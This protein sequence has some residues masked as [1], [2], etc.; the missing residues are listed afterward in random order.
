M[1]KNVYY[2]K[3]N[4]ILFKNL[5]EKNHICQYKKTWFTNVSYQKLFRD[6]K[7]INQP[8]PSKTIKDR[9]ITSLVSRF[10]SLSR[11]F[12]PLRGQTRE[13]ANALIASMHK[14]HNPD[15]VVDFNNGQNYDR[16]K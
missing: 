3:H 5:T 8:L 13:E 10:T 15:K 9:P 11:T 12:R 4:N 2:G 1:Q 14:P 16:H 7:R 6:F